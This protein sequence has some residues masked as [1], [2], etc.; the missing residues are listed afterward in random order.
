MISSSSSSSVIRKTSVPL[1]RISVR[2]VASATPIRKS[3]Y[4]GGEE[5]SLTTSIIESLMSL[6][7]ISD[8]TSESSLI[9]D[10]S[11]L[12]EKIEIERKELKEALALKDA[13]MEELRMEIDS[14][15]T[16]VS[17]EM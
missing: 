16:K 1:P 11:H 8:A 15:K 6:D 2:G 9:E 14:L 5:N 4:V 3:M 17:R 7:G 12:M 10:N 13:K